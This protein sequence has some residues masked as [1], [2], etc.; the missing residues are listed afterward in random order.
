MAAKTIADMDIQGRRVF[1][2]LDLDVPLTPA[3]GVSDPARIRESIPT[4]QL[5]TSRGARVVLAAHLGRPRGKQNAGLSLMPIAACLVELLDRE[6][7]LA[8]EPT[9]DG[10]KKVVAD[11]RDGG[12]AMLENLRFASGEEANDESFARA[13]AGYADVYINDAFAATH[14][15]HASIAGMPRFVSTRGMGLVLEREVKFL[16]RLAG[17]IEEPF[18]AVIGGTKLSE[19]IA[20]MESL[21][22]RADAILIGGA[23]ANTFLKARGGRLGTS[24]VEGDKL[25]WARNFLLKAEQTQV[26]VLLPVDLMAASGPEARVG[27]VVPA[28]R[29]PDELAAL[30]I[31]PETSRHFADGLANARTLFWHGPMGAFESAP[32][33]VGT[34]AVAQ[35]VAAIKF[36]LTLV[37]GRDAAAALRRVGAADRVTH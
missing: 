17:E 10:A 5:A 37:A 20:V 26:D 27:Q 35:A 12:V 28:L 15:P 19:K 11:L 7:V 30:D 2:R 18:V 34:T 8:D 36:G 33:S 9:G 21:L 29:V 32:F 14:L 1:I 13:L 3:G 4:I 22:N 25:A 31:G 23:I 24:L 6:V 16:G